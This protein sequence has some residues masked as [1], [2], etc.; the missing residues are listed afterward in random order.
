MLNQKGLSPVIILFSL[1][2]LGLCFGGGYLLGKKYN[3]QPKTEQNLSEAKPAPIET[4]KISS[5]TDIQN[6]ESEYG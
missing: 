4:S 5:A 2:V 6:I 3:S 1:L